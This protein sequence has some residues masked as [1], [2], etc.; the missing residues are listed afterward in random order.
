MLENSCLFKHS[1]MPPN[2]ELNSKLRRASRLRIEFEQAAL[3]H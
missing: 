1:K 3:S 2:Y